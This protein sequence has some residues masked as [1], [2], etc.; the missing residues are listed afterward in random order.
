MGET[1]NQRWQE[2]LGDLLWCTLTSATKTI[3]ELKVSYSYIWVINQRSGP[4]HSPLSCVT[5][6]SRGFR[7][8][9]WVSA[10]WETW[11]GATD[12]LQI[13]AWRQERLQQNNGSTAA[14]AL[15]QPQL[16]LTGREQKSF[17]CFLST[18]QL[19]QLTLIVEQ[20]HGLTTAGLN[21]NW[22]L[23]SYCSVFILGSDPAID[24]FLVNVLYRLNG[25]EC[26]FVAKWK[27]PC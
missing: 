15:V 21:W 26:T 24:E 11:P 1:L 7:E 6:A 14:G 4:F 10:L 22:I 16:K 3:P 25:L 2:V 18:V 20:G 17:M 23:N 12:P 27:S 19:G 8:M 5:S 9:G 13:T